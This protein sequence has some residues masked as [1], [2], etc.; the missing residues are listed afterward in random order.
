MTEYK[1]L[2]TEAHGRDEELQ[3]ARIFSTGK[4]AQGMAVVFIQ[5]MCAAFH[6]FEPAWRDGGLNDEHLPF[7][8]KRLAARTRKVLQMLR[9]NDLDKIA[10]VAE[11]EAVLY[12]IESAKTMAKLADLAEKV[13]TVN[14]TLTDA[15]EKSC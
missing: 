14:H 1:T 15:L 9:A 12:A 3:W 2:A 13:H 4:A 7:F 5:K 10:G 8:R 11:L 6:E